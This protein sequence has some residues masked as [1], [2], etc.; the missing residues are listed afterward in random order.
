MDGFVFVQP[1][2]DAN[3]ALVHIRLYGSGIRGPFIH[4]SL[5][6]RQGLRVKR[7]LGSGVLGP[8]NPLK[9]IFSVDGAYWAHLPTTRYDKDGAYWA[10]LPT[11]RYDKDGGVLGP[12]SIYRQDLSGWGVLGPPS[13]YR[14]DLSGWGVLGPPSD[15]HRDLVYDE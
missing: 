15:Y 12:P 3:D 1:D 10:H 5:N 7:K 11:T 8:F 4:S 14:R 2:A 13:D 6:T 9:I